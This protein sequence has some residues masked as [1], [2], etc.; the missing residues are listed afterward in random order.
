MTN[1]GRFR[2]DH[3]LP[4]Q[5]G[6]YAVVAQGDDD[7]RRSNWLGKST[8]IGAVRWA[9]HGV[10]AADTLD[11]AISH[12]EKQMAVDV[13][14]SDGMFVT[15]GKA[16]GKSA[17]LRVIVADGGVERELFGDAA[18]AEIDSR[19]G[20]ES[21][22]FDAT[23]WVTQKNAARLVTARASDRTELVADWLALGPLE[24]AAE[25]VAK[26]VGEWDRQAAEAMAEYSVHSRALLVDRALLVQAEAD[27]RAE[28]E[29][30]Q[31]LVDRAAEAAK[32]WAA[33]EDRRRRAGQAKA[34][35][36][37]LQ[38]VQA[39]Q[40]EVGV[41]THAER[42]DAL[43][44]DQAVKDRRAEL[45]AK[46][47]EVLR[48]ARLVRGEFDGKCPV[49]C[50][51]CPVADTVRSSTRQAKA[52]HEAARQGLGA[53]QQTVDR[54]AAEA[55]GKL[56]AVAKA[57]R[58]FEAWRVRMDRAMARVEAVGQVVVG[59]EPPRVEAPDVRGAA[60]ALGEAAAALQQ[61]DRAVAAAEKAKGRLDECNRELVVH[62]QALR[63]L[64]R[65]GAQ[66]RVAI[67]AL[68]VIER[69]ANQML[70]RAAIDLTVGLVYGRELQD[71]AE[72]CGCGR[73][74]P[75]TAK[76]KVCDRCGAVRGKK[77]DDKLYVEQSSRSGAADD[78]AGVALQLAAARWLRG[79][80]EAP[81]SVIALD[82]PFGALDVVHRQ[83]L[84]AALV[85][86][87]RD[88]FEQAFIVAHS[89]DVLEAMPHRITIKSD[90]PW[91]RAEVA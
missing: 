59:E 31:R 19:V 50:G 82:E 3:E 73:A 67:E 13:E 75:K 28:L 44:L 16:R 29:E 38:G 37:E 84:A 33:W 68:A 14:F 48:L 34:A 12:G 61:Y 77:R 9:L 53:D 10:V 24:R 89:P 15:R 90:G 55:R 4:L 5:A 88:G 56:D 78:L 18:Q 65:G 76:V 70:A 20:L 8:L 80:R 83:A 6:V 40:P 23:V 91:S 49:T 21:K 58:A 42:S 1:F 47:K 32:A 51:E 25:W 36:E 27:R 64:G 7:P 74:F 81:W 54:M 63:I 79:A 87:V 69:T 85:A 66:R 60:A 17:E 46:E 11:E 62:R 22:D 52:A 72:V 26:R 45:E 35:A 86:M 43:A 41:P 2:G 57:A 71:M 39:E 30:V